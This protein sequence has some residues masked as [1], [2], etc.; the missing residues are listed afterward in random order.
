MTS[1]LISIV[2][3]VLFWSLL[4]R[5]IAKTEELVDDSLETA[6]SLLRQG[7]NRAYVSELSSQAELAEKLKTVNQRRVKA[8]L[9]EA[10]PD[11]FDI[12]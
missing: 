2:F 11:W 8:G 10:S 7:K 1:F 9:K 6:H 5:T 12:Q 4:K 3:I